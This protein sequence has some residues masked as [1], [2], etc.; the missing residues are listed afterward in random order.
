MAF[1]RSVAGFPVRL[2][3]HRY[4]HRRRRW[5]LDRS[6]RPRRPH[7]RRAH[8]RRRRARARLL[9][10]GRPRGDRLRRQSRARASARGADRR[11][12]APRPRPRRAR[13]SRRWRRTLGLVLARDGARHRAHRQRQ[14]DAGDPRGLD[15]ARPRSARLHADAVRRRGRA[16]RRGDRARARHPRILVPAAPGILCAE[17]VA[18]AELEESFVATCRC[19]LDGDLA[20]VAARFAELLAAA[21]D[22]YARESLSARRSRQDIAH[23]HALRRPELRAG[24]SGAA[25]PRRFRPR[26]AQERVSRGAS[27]QIRSPR[28]RGRRSRS[29]TCG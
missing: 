28:S 15:R 20:P 19:P 25:R 7:A 5:R 23:R 6:V 14:H 27:A 10:Q 1:G 4:P 9:R 24:D 13:R 21:G 26:L 12:H 11:R 16:A 18:A 3:V 29:S 17:G 2:A 8:E 22:W